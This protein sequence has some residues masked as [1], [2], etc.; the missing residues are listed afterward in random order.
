MLCGRRVAT[1]VALTVAV[2]LLTCGAA[3]AVT[4]G[5]TTEPAGSSFGTACA[6]PSSSPIFAIQQQAE[7]AYNYTVPQGGGQI[8][9]WSFNT[10]GATVGKPYGLAVVRP[11][12]FG[13]LDYIGGDIENLPT[14]H[15]TVETYTL[16][17]PI[18]VQAG[19][20][21]SAALEQ[22]T[23][24]GCYWIG[25]SLTSSDVLSPAT[26]ELTP[27]SPVTP[28]T[29]VSSELLNMSADV[30]QSQ[31][32]GVSDQALE[33]PITAGSDAV[34]SLTATNAG[35][36]TSSINLADTVP[37]GLK[38]KAVIS[39]ADSCTVTGQTVTCTVAKAPSTIGIVVSAAKAG[40]YKN[41]ATVS[42]SLADP[43]TANNSA[44][45]TLT[46]NA[47]TGPPAPAKCHVPSLKGA[48]LS[49]AKAILKLL[50]CK[51]GRVTKKSSAT[52]AKGD[53]ISTSPR[54]GKTEPAGT[55]IAIASSSGKP[56]K[57]K[58]SKRARRLAR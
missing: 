41:S 47:A 14:L 35:P 26:G 29:S 49:Q 8:V 6:A 46:V 25:G 18:S 43:N 53:V 54:A 19:D 12:G 28:I 23:V 20:L 50:D 31:D 22:T 42:G 56:M 40:S 58:M 30:A 7:S 21:I 38:I 37:S 45:A 33:S 32:V 9:S 15:Q 51:V 17:A 39:G 10:T 11:D 16:A 2:A 52:V 48:S 5:N 3:G 4:V 1:G 57:H 34:F 13:G 44:S 27:G 24:A 55:K 36:G